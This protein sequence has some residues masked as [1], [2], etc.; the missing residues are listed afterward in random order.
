MRASGLCDSCLHTLDMAYLGRYC[1]G[2]YTGACLIEMQHLLLFLE[3][4]AQRYFYC[5]HSF[6]VGFARL[7]SMGVGLG[8][9]SIV[10]SEGSHVTLGVPFFVG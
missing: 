2:D 1:G 4:L 5:I 9:R 7:G 8:C 3:P 10:G 6:R